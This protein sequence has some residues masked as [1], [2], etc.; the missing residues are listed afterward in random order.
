MTPGRSHATHTLQLNG[1][2]GRPVRGEAIEPRESRGT[3]IIAHGF[4][5]FA[6]WGFFPYL[7]RKLADAGFRAVSFD[8]SGSGVGAD[9]ENFTDHDAFAE[10]TYTRELHDLSVVAEECTQR[11]W[12]LDGYG[13]LGHSRGGGM[14]ILHAA[15]DERVRAL[16]TWAAIASVRNNFPDDVIAGWRARGHLDVQNVRTGQVMQLGTAILDEV[17]RLEH[18]ELDIGGAASRLAI[19]WLIVH[20]TGDE[21]VRSSAALTL[22]ARATGGLAELMLVE[23]SNHGFGGSHPLTMV[24]DDLDKVIARTSQFF[25]RHLG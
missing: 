17:E 15:R 12:L 25:R 19:P 6:R 23:G 24:P 7:A 4:K 21:T 20:G 5:G 11:G 1:S 22:H 13:L 18:S 10:N 2:N 8:F 3:I 9:R 16:V 14:V